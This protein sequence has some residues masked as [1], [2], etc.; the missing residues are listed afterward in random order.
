M[1]TAKQIAAAKKNIKKA[2]KAWKEMSHRE[3]AI[4]QPSGRKRKK[5]GTT[6]E[7]EFYRIE[8][9]PKEEFV[10]FRNQDVGEPG[11]IERLA[12]KRESGSWD[13]V[14]WLVDKKFAHIE[15]NKLV[16]DHKDAK[17]LFENLG[18]AP[19]HVKGDVFKAEDRPN[20]PEKDKPT[21]AQKRARSK[22]IKEAQ[23]ARHSA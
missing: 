6:G 12:G 17:D 21:A 9:R 4:A 13:T 2:Q 7:G 23:K 8:V 14:T 20:V 1:A 15:R 3:H 5:P 19:K 10:T 16:P 18:S 22:N 11:G